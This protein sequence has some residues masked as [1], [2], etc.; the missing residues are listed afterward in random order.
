MPAKVEQNRL[1]TEFHKKKE[2]FISKDRNNI[3]R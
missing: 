1:R 2:T 3:G